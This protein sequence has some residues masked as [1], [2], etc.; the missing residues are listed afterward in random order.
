MLSFRHWV[1][2]KKSSLCL[3]QINYLMTLKYTDSRTVLCKSN[4]DNLHRL[5]FTKQAASEI[6]ANVCCILCFRVDKCCE[7]GDKTEQKFATGDEISTL[8]FTPEVFSIIRYGSTAFPGLM[9]PTY[10]YQQMKTVLRPGYAV[11]QK[12]RTSGRAKV[13]ND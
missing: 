9:S 11:M 12:K 8:I 3:K 7:Q 2:R 5:K 13:N 10:S 1:H 6:C 4:E